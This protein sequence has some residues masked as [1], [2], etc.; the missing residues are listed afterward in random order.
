MSST[1]KYRGP[2]DFAPWIALAL[3]TVWCLLVGLLWS[4]AQL[5]AATGGTA[6]PPANPFTFTLALLTGKTRWPGPA[7]TW[8]AYA[9]TAVLVVIAGCIVWLLRR[10]RSSRSR[11]DAAARHLAGRAELSALTEQGAA[12]TATRLKVAGDSPGIAIG[13]AISTGQPL[14]GSWE[15]LHVDVWGPRTGKTTARAIPAIVTAPGPVVVTSNKRDVVD[16]TRGVRA[17]GGRILVFDPQDLTGE[18][19]TW[20]WNPLSYVTDVDKAVRLAAVFAA[21]SRT[22][23]SRADAYFDAAGQELL[24]FLLLAAASGNE[25]ITTVYRWASDPT[26]TVP[27]DLLRAGGHELPAE[28]VAG[29]INY[30]DKQR[31]GIFATAKNAIGCLVNPAVTRWVTPDAD[32]R[33]GTGGGGRPQF[34]PHAFATST[35]TLYLL[36]REGQGTAGPLVTALTMATLEAAEHQAG[37]SPGGRLRVP[38]LGCLDEAANVCRWRDLPDLYSHYGSRGIVLMTIL[39]SWAQGVEV[40]GEHGMNK[41]WS[42][43]NVRVYGGGASDT[44]FLGDLAALLGDFEADTTSLSV[45]RSSGMG[46]G[47]S[48]TAAT[49]SERV[50]DVADLAALSRG[51]ALVFASG[52]RPVL[53]RTQPWQHGPHAERIRASL[54]RYAPPEELP[55]HELEDWDADAG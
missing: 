8:W 55:R 52:T 4:A 20:W 12:A 6:A 3:T 49:R 42:A 7:A 31:A 27:V 5:A 22:A 26:D 48:L 19:P 16:A 23:G 41:L 25:P 21:Y 45:Q 38:M 46:V 34:D 50:L 36:S 18:P 43:A 44:K 10:S 39:Q 9:E 13:A 40:W 32:D 47:R 33:A 11:V 51:R 24:A 54:E 2:S 14:Y 53:V 28:S 35:D 30:P 29:T 37:R 1:R 17:D 15:D